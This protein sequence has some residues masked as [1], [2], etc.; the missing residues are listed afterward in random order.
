VSR[1]NT[2][3]VDPVPSQFVGHCAEKYCSDVTNS[4]AR[5]ECMV[6]GQLTNLND[7]FGEIIFIQ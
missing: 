2:S 5:Q 6:K 1:E 3:A 7:R 4:Q